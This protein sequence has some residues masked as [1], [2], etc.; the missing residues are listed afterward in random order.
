MDLPGK[1]G[2]TEK[3]QPRRKM[4]FQRPQRIIYASCQRRMVYSN[5]TLTSFDLKLAFTFWNF[6]S[7]PLAMPAS[8][9]NYRSVQPVLSLRSLCGDG[10]E[11]VLL[12]LTGGGRSREKKIKREVV[13]TLF[14]KFNNQGQNESSR[15][16]QR[17]C[18]HEMTCRWFHSH[19]VMF[20]PMAC[21]PPPQSPGALI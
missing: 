4:L 19:V 20:T 12:W 14:R 11:G 17:R 5:K 1:K 6:L 3:Q 10:T 7:N 16:A 15:E 8:S 9:Q 18:V 21:H 2:Q 13:E